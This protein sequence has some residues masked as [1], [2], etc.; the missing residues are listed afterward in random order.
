M[1]VC[2]SRATTA[3]TL[4]G[5]S[6]GD[7][8]RGSGLRSAIRSPTALLTGSLTCGTWTALRRRRRLRPHGH[9]HHEPPVLLAWLA[10]L[11]SVVLL[12][13]Q[14]PPVGREAVPL[15]R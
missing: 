11:V 12:P 2:A 4:R 14:G 7:T 3:T 6:I 1:P 8:K 9:R 5:R 10:R 15:L 13:D